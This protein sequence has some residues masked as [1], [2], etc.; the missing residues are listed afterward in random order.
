MYDGY[1]F[2]ENWNISVSH[3]KT[4]WTLILVVFDFLLSLKSVFENREIDRK[5]KKKRKNLKSQKFAS[6]GRLPSMQK[7]NKT[8]QNK[9]PQRKSGLDVNLYPL[10]FRIQNESN[11]LF[12]HIFSHGSNPQWFDNIPSSSQLVTNMLIIYCS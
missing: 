4:T 10:G 9:N 7:Q 3:F 2:I 1:P 11:P 12:I 6:R 5:K 8:K